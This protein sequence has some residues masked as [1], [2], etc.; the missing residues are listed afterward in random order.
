MNVFFVT[1]IDTGSGKTVATG[2]MAR[3]LRRR[4]VRALTAKLAQTGCAGISEDV[5]LHRRLMGVSLTPLD[6]QWLTCPCVF[7]YPAS[8]ALAARL[9]G[10]RIE[11][12]KIDGA[13]A[14][15]ASGCDI[16]VIEGVGGWMVPLSDS[17]LASDFVAERRWPVIIVSSP[18][19]GSINHTLLTLESVAAAGLKIAG[20]VYNMGIASEPAIAADTRGV[21]LKALKRVGRP[22]ALVDIPV[23]TDFDDP[24]DVDFSRIFECVTHAL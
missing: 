14:G 15:L 12:S 9:A 16:L 22:G 19:L 10:E 8:P 24:P 6:E 5:A 21:L 18:R 2:L 11:A 4:G 20:I 13:F 23:V 17:L 7:P 3:Y 1:G